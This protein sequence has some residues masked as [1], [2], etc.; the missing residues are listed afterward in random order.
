[1]HSLSKQNNIGRD[2]LNTQRFKIKHFTITVKVF[3]HKLTIKV[4]FQPG[5]LYRLLGVPLNEFKMDEALDSSYVFDKEIPF[6]NEQLCEATSYLQM[7]E[8]IEAFLLK[9]LRP[10]HDESSIDS[11]LH[12]IIASGGLMPMDDIKA[13]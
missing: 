3:N 4:G 10:L 11:V 12:K 1:M 6:V 8:I 13:Q 5:G 7:I 9:K 2:I